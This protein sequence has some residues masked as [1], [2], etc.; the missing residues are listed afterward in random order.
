MW[1]LV[2]QQILQILP[3]KGLFDARAPASFSSETCDLAHAKSTGHVGKCHKIRE[4]GKSKSC[5]SNHPWAVWLQ[6]HHCC[7]GASPPSPAPARE[8][9]G[10]ESLCTRGWQ[11]R[12]AHLWCSQN[13]EASPALSAFPR[14][15]QGLLSSQCSVLGQSKILG[16]YPHHLGTASECG[17]PK[18][19]KPDVVLRSGSARAA[20]GD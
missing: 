18:H 2:A 16:R 1:F 7:P 13:A 10:P 14:D 5:P 19:G 3:G 20:G 12:S 4:E 17:N 11:C 9:E 8:A 6:R 15:S